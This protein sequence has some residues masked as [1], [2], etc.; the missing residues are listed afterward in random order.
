MANENKGKVEAPVGVV[1]FNV[2]DRISEG[3]AAWR[4]G[5]AGSKAAIEGAKLAKDSLVSFLRGLYPTRQAGEPILTA[6]VKGVD[7]LKLLL[8]WVYPVKP[9]KVEVKNVDL[10]EVE[11]SL[12]ALVAEF[13]ADQQE[14]AGKGLLALLAKALAPAK[15]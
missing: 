2:A 15:E 7:D 8:K 1:A 9:V 11:A 5:Q 12:K 13:P 6:L 3:I 4:S 10:S 14:G